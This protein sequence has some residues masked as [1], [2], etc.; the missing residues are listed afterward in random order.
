MSHFK[1]VIFDLDGLIVDTE[2]LHQ[3]ALNAFLSLAGVDFQ[4]DVAEYGKIFTGRSIYENGEYLRER[5]SLPQTA[6]QIGQAH[7]AMFTVLIADAENLEP[8]TGL[9]DLVTW[10]TAENFQLA[11][12]S[13][14][15][16]EQVQIILRNL[17]LHG[18]FTAVV[19]NDGT[20]KP[21][22][23]P[24]VYS[25]ALEK[26]GG[27]AKETV[28][29]EDSTSGVMAAHA[30]GLFVIAV[31]NIFTQHQDFSKANLVLQD[32]HQVQAYLKDAEKS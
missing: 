23:A 3:R 6:E 27:R 28:A 7:H 13:S 31:P 30:A 16:P 9:Q 1:N 18:H 12:A 17:N 5:F 4:F 15:R 11:I 29:L 26:L 19:G 24:D 21:K 14:S 2:P 10:L 25:L 22:P 32:L 8:M 20:L